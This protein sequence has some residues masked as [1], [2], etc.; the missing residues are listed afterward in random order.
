[1]RRFLS[2]AL[3]LALVSAT[4]GLASAQ[5]AALVAAGRDFALKICSNCHVVAADQ[6]SPPLMKPPAPS[7]SEIAARPQTTE[8]LLRDFLGKP[9]GEA[10]Q[11]SRMPAFML[12][13][14]QVRQVVAYLLSLKPDR[15]REEKR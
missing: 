12:S 6:A 2:F 10:R 11:N 13:D 15:E 1:M 9:H 8:A 7:F 3:A 5:D 4:S 14:L